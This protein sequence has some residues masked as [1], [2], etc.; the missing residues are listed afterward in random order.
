MAETL[1]LWVLVYFLSQD[2]PRSSAYWVLSLGLLFVS[3]LSGLVF[4]F[5][6]VAVITIMLEQRRN[7]HLS[8]GWLNEPRSVM[9]LLTMGILVLALGFLAGRADPSFI[10]L[11]IPPDR[12]TE[13]AFSSHARPARARSDVPLWR[14]SSFAR[15]ALISMRTARVFCASLS[16]RYRRSDLAIARGTQRGYVLLLLALLGPL[17]AGIGIES[18]SGAI[19]AVTF[20]LARF[21]LTRACGAKEIPLIGC[22]ISA[23]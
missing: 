12:F 15:N 14:Y 11:R 22:F 5:M 23:P 4:L 9:S 13:N 21:L 16:A 10:L 17:L 20:I 19:L 18:S 2:H 1:A 3:L 8:Q 6:V 7:V